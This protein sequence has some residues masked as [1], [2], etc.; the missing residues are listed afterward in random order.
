MAL[1]RREKKLVCMLTPLTRKFGATLHSA[2][3]PIKDLSRPVLLKVLRTI[4][5][6]PSELERVV[7]HFPAIIL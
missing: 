7:S 1:R 6:Y 3:I 5:S 2:Q 4:I